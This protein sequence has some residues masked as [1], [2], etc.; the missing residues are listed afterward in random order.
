VFGLTSSRYEPSIATSTLLLWAKLARAVG[1]DAV[2]RKY[3]DAALLF[4]PDHPVRARA[5]RHGCDR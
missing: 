1:N 5:L 4:E 2:A 3:V